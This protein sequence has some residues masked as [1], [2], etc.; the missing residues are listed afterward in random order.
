MKFVQTSNRYSMSAQKGSEAPGPPQHS[1]AQTRRG[2]GAE[3]QATGTNAT[4]KP[5][6]IQRR[7]YI[8]VLDHS[9]QS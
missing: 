9:L 4:L 2:V 3:T 7:V 8:S 6:G 1:A 5:V